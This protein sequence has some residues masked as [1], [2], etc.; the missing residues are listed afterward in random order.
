MSYKAKVSIDAN[1]V[2]EERSVLFIQ[3]LLLGR[4]KNYIDKG[5]KVSIADVAMINRGDLELVKELCDNDLIYKL[6]G[7]AGWNTSSNTLGTALASLVIN[8]HYGYTKALEKHI[9]L[10]V[11]EDIGYMG[12]A[13]G[14]VIDNYLPQLGLNYFNSGK[15]KGEVSERVCSE[16]SNYIKDNMSLVYGKYEI[17]DCYMPWCRMF[18]VALKIKER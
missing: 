12:Y 11:Y 3:T 10:R 13:R 14:Y 9:A 15:V 4:T 16:I 18:E 5:Y 1:G 2:K 7:Y 8:V 6:A 17:E